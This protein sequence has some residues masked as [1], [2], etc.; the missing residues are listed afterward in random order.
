MQGFFGY[1]DKSPWSYDSKYYLLH[2]ID[3]KQQDKVKIE[4]YDCES[5]EL[6]IRGDTPAFDFQQGSMLK[7]LN[8]KSYHIIY[9]TVEDGNLAAKIKDAVSG[10]KSRTIPVPIQTVN[11]D[12]TEALT[13]NYKRLD[14]IRPEYGYSVD[15]K[16]FHLIC[17][18]KKTGFGG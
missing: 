17:L 9:N 3:K 10:K 6:N 5:G 11:F 16:C 7:W 1:Y 12:G 13:L 14:R 2:I 18:M 15:V 8:Q 4:V